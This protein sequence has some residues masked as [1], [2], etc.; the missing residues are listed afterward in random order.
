MNS[1]SSQRSA[2]TDGQP[3]DGPPDDGAGRNSAA[4]GRM[5]GGGS[6][7]GAPA[8]HRWRLGSILREQWIF[9]AL[10]GL[11][12][13][14]DLFLTL[15]RAD[16]VALPGST[17]MAVLAIVAWRYPVHGG[18]A[19]VV[20]MT[21]STLALYGFDATTYSFGLVSVLPAENAA[22][23]LI[24]LYLFWKRSSSQAVPVAAAL[25]LSCLLAIFIRTEAPSVLPGLDLAQ[26]LGLGFLQLILSVGTGLY[27][28][29]RQ[30]HEPDSPMWALLRRQWPVIAGLSVFLFTEFLNLEDGQPAKVGLLLGCAVMSV[31]AVVAPIRPAEAPAL[32]ALALVL[33][34]LSSRFLHVTTYTFLLGAIPATAI[35][36]GMLLIAFSARYATLS[37]ALWSGGTLVS[38]ALTALFVIPG[39]GYDGELTRSTLVASL[40][41]GGLLLVL[42]VGTGMYF[43]ARDEERVKSVRTAVVNAQQS[44]RMA[45][46]RE[47]HDLVAHHVTGIVVQ[48][49]AARMVAETSP[50]AAADALERIESSGT[51]ALAAM[52]RLVGS[53]RDAEPA[54]APEATEQATTDL[55]SDLITLVE[56]AERAGSE[57]GAKPR[58]EPSISLGRDIPQEVTRS[59][60][61]L[62]QEA[63]TNA[64]KHALD[65]TTINVSVR[66]H[67]R[68]LHL[69]IADDGSAAR[70]QPIGGSGG[71]GLIGMRERVELLGGRFSAGPGE[72]G[73]RVQAWLPLSEQDEE[74]DRG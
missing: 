54:G 63:L 45:L 68:H 37:Q 16:P 53:M 71:Y 12:W 11:V 57:H 3:D 39:T 70:P 41:M 60:L 64:D 40:F 2:T 61:R 17:L 52:R 32:G 30:S 42:S 4:T 65:A 25:A 44:E 47:L 31:L 28:R 46:A 58:I 6:G 56:R 26:T 43:R 21:G 38:S 35:A 10:L 72:V 7:K 48:A 62:V 55:E 33:A 67:R 1:A 51:D 27:L 19:A 18:L 9:A 13:C 14:G 69:R 50:G 23:L 34:A 8:G 66:T 5:P 73:W 15:H 36:A 22:A 49:Q 29:G 74:E 24:V 20:V 59:A